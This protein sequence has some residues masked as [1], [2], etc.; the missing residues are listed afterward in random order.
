M[1]KTMLNTYSE[2]PVRLSLWFQSVALIGADFLKDQ[3]EMLSSGSSL[4]EAQKTEIKDLLWEELEALLD[5]IAEEQQDKRFKMT[6]WW[7]TIG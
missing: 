7:N 6:N 3:F 5:D 2:L 4:T 1:L